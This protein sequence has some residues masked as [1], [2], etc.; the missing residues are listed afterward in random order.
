MDELFR[1][2]RHARVFLF[3]AVALGVLGAAATIAQMTFLSQVVGAAFVDGAGLDLL[4]QPLLFLMAAGILRAGLLWARE[5]VAGRG[6]VRVKS[7]IRDR[8]FA[9]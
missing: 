4:T 7:E 3:S 1:G 9:R 5:V 2:P 8:L 6:A